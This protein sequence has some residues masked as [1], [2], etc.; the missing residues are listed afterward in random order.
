M[1]IVKLRQKIR[2]RRSQ[3]LIHSCIYYELNESVVTDHKWQE[4]AFELA[5]L[6][7]DNPQDC[8]INFFDDAFANWTGS[9]GG[10]HL[11]LR[12][13]WVVSKSNYILQLCR[14]SLK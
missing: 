7:T 11:P 4:W 10:S 3:M 2:Q 12:H 6:Q 8:K 9:H 14:N 13:P 5:K 1:D